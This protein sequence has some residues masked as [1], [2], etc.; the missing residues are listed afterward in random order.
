V[1]QQLLDRH[2][3]PDQGPVLDE[4]RT[5]RGGPLQPAS[6]IRLTTVRAVRP[7]VPLAMANWVSTVRRCLLPATSDRYDGWCATAGGWLREKAMEVL[8]LVLVVLGLPLLALAVLTLL[9]HGAGRLYAAVM[10]HRRRGRG[11]RSGA[12]S[13]TDVIDA[14]R[15]AEALRARP[16]V[17]QSWTAWQRRDRRP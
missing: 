14:R 12:D 15:D 1:R 5:R 8:L 7:L 4:Q 13:W 11:A 16:D 10:G 2:L 3:V 17:D 9:G 6:S